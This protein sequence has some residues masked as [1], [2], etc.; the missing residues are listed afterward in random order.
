MKISNRHGLPEPLVRAL[1]QDKYSRGDSRASVTG[2]IG[3]PRVAVLKAKHAA[4]IE[5]D[6][7]DRLWSLFGT[8]VHNIIEEGSAGLPDYIAEERIFSEVDGWRISGSIDLQHHTEGE[9]SLRDWKV[10]GA[11]AVMNTKDDW[12]KQLNLYA[13]LVEKEKGVKV[14]DIQIGAIIRDW[15]R[16]E[17]QR[18]PDYPQTPVVM[19]DIPLWGYKAREQYL[20]GRITL[21]KEAHRRAEWGEDLPFCTPEEMW[22]K[23]TVYAVKK[24]GAARATSLHSDKNEALDKAI[25]TKQVMETRIGERTKCNSF[26][27]VS[28]FCTQ[29]AEYLKSKE[30]HV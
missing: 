18:N 12:G 24:L 19:V 3:S 27:E 4:E 5:T 7:M 21:H 11:W 15:K 1:S 23:P 17:A 9:V 29:H 13:L 2:L 10:T 14:R 16:F 20:L 8:T 28:K 26:C 6:A 22:E 25:A 30:Y